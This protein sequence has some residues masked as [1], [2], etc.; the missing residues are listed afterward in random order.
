MQWQIENYGETPRILVPDEA[1]IFKLNVAFP[2]SNISLWS[3]VKLLDLIQRR[4]HSR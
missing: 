1:L 3:H 2:E 4:I